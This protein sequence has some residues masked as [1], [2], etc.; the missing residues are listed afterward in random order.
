MNFTLVWRDVGTNLLSL[1]RDVGT[2]ILTLNY[3]A[4]IFYGNSRDPKEDLYGPSKLNNL[5]RKK[6]VICENSPNKMEKSG[7]I[8]EWL[9][10]EKGLQ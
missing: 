7:T 6:F 8:W 3:R 9:N 2:N 10:D 1:T 5:A 4:Q